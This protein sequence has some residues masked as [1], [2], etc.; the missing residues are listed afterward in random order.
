MDFVNI[1][2]FLFYECLTAYMYMPHMQATPNEIRGGHRIPYYQPH[3]GWE[4]NLD[5]LEE[6]QSTQVLGHLSASV[7]VF[8]SMYIVLEIKTDQAQ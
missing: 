5:S 8:S 7:Y 2:L 1:G 4:S 3:R 6:Q